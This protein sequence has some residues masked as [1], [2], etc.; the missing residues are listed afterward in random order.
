MPLLERILRDVMAG[1]YGMVKQNPTYQDVDD[2][3]KAEDNKPTKGRGKGSATTA[4]R[5]E[6]SRIGVDH[7]KATISIGTESKPVLQKANSMVSCGAPDHVMVGEDLY[8]VS[9]KSRSNTPKPHEDT[10]VAFLNP[11]MLPPCCISL[12]SIGFPVWRRANW[13]ALALPDGRR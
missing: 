8:A 5:A 11:L 7:E 2:L 10:E 9:T 4:T 13:C 6:L 1:K 3:E 12:Y